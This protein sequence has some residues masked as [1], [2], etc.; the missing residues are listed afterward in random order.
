MKFS[1]TEVDILRS[2]TGEG[3]KVGD[4]TIACARVT[5]IGNLENG[6]TLK[7][8]AKEGICLGYKTN[9]AGNA[10]VLD[11]DNLKEASNYVLVFRDPENEDGT[12]GDVS[13]ILTTEDIAELYGLPK[14]EAELMNLHLGALVKQRG[15][16]M[17]RYTDAETNKE[18]LLFT[19]QFDRE[20]ND[21][22]LDDAMDEAMEN[23]QR[24]MNNLDYRTELQTDNFIRMFLMSI[25]QTGQGRYNLLNRDNVIEQA[26]K[27]ISGI[28]YWED[29]VLHKPSVKD[30]NESISE[31][32]GHITI[33]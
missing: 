1:V 32:A 23:Y 10:I 11:E 27:L 16:M 28:T 18:A 29:G 19:N 22:V 3:L 24:M 4:K 21:A 17:V 30:I 33:A 31:I 8:L 14:E 5:K 9:E 20:I 2:Q 15:L 7:D 13:I 12:P 25:D 26:A 6:K